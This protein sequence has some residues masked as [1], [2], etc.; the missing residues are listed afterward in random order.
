MVD[1]AGH[2]ASTLLRWSAGALCL[3]RLL[4]EVV[5]RKPWHRSPRT[6]NG[7]CYLSVGTCHWRPRVG[8][9]CCITMLYNLVTSWPAPTL[10]WRIACTFAQE[11][12]TAR[13]GN[14][15]IYA[16][17]D[18]SRGRAMAGECLSS[19]PQVLLS[20]KAQWLAL[21]AARLAVR[22]DLP[23]ITRKARQKPTYIPSLSH[24]S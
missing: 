9:G 6:P 19:W 23:R 2:I 22:D 12:T 15:P 1:G 20:T 13:R 24:C 18:T 16:L 10:P 5:R 21:A 14:F 8:R 3:A 7:A 11:C 4:S 17:P